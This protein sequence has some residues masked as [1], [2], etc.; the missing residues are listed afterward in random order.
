MFSSTGLAVGIDDQSPACVSRAKENAVS[1]LD[2]AIMLS[3]STTTHRSLFVA[4]CS[5]RRCTS[6]FSI[7]QCP[8]RVVILLERFP[9]P[10]GMC[11]SSPAPSMTISWMKRLVSPCNMAPQKSLHR[12]LG[13]GLADIARITRPQDIAQGNGAGF[14]HQDLRRP[15]A[16]PAR[17]IPQSCRVTPPLQPAG[18]PDQPGPAPPC[19]SCRELALLAVAV[20]AGKS[21][22]RAC[23][24][25]CSMRAAASACC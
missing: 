10:S 25:D 8:L 19:Q 18:V 15:T 9:E 13:R 12:G 4:G 22:N 11:D 17:R 7:L 16:A 3:V 20:W 14:M 24:C 1:A 2:G 21:R 5:S 6:K 23:N